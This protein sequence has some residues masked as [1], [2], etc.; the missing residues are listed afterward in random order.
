MIRSSLLV[1]GLLLVCGCSASSEGVATTAVSFNVEGAP[2]VEFSVPDMMCPDSCVAKTKEILSQ[3][4][5][6]KDVKVDFDSKTATVAIEA[7]QFSVDDAIA[8]MK[9]HSFNHTTV[10][11]T[12][13]QPTPENHGG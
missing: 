9:D 10:K 13:E 1:C 7:G 8:A 2:T 11:Q 3:Q 6:A 4:P 12:A 5:G